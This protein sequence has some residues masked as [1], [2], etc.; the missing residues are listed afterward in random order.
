MLLLK[1]GVCCRGLEVAVCWPPIT[2]VDRIRIG[3][4][5]SMWLE[6]SRGI[7]FDLRTLCLLLKSLSYVCVFLTY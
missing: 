7:L 2:T 3:S 5:V 1:E 4:Y 6:N